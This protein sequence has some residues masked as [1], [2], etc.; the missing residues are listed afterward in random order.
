MK[1]K[2]FSL[3]LL[4]SFFISQFSF[5]QSKALTIGDKVPELQFKMVNYNDKSAKLS[6]FKGKLLILDFWFAQCTGCVLH[7]PKNDSLQRKFNG[8]IQFLLI[9]DLRD[10]GN[11]EDALNIFFSKRKNKAGEKFQLPTAVED[12]NAIK[13]FP[14]KIDPHYVWINQEG[15]VIGITGSEEVTEKNIAAL[16]NGKQVTQRMKNDIEFDYSKPLLVNDNGGVVHNFIYRSLLTGYLD[17]MSSPALGTPKGSSF[18]RIGAVNF[19][20][21]SLYGL[22]YPELNHYQYVYRNRVLMEV[23]DLSKYETN[24][25]NYDSWKYNN[26]YTYELIAGVNT[27]M[28]K[29]QEMMRQDLDRY[30]GLVI[31]KEKRNVKCLVLRRDSENI[32]AYSKGGKTEQNIGAGIIDTAK[33]AHNISL[34]E[35]VETLNLSLSLPVLDETRITEKITLDNLPGDLQNINALRKALNK[36]GLS[37]TEEERSIDLIIISEKQQQQ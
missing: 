29:L 33:Y 27:S 8:K 37:I 20:I 9:N 24:D 2:K 36:Y 19:P 34:Y 22:A 13:L 7:F 5:S 35:F 17:G 11:D 1:I 15:K 12:T 25:E 28:E 18:S 21:I 14:H 4:F 26:T 31:R 3:L 23:K 16:L 10:K 32:T 30:F 6:D